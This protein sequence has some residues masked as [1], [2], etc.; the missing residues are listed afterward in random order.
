MKCNRKILCTDCPV[1]AK[2]P[3]PVRRDKRA[4]RPLAGSASGSLVTR[5]A[6][7]LATGWYSCEELG[8]ALYGHA[9]DD[10]VWRMSVSFRARRA[11]NRLKKLGLVASRPLDPKGEEYTLLEGEGVL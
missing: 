1:R 6:R 4:R 2:C 11:V 10:R 3:A 8:Y 9:A 5:A 7:I